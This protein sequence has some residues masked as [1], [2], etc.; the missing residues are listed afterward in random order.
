MDIHTKIPLKNFT[1]MKLGGIARF[2]VD[3]HTKDEVA[4]I[5]K[6]AKQNSLSVFVLGGGSNVIATDKGFNGII[7]RM[8]ISGFEI[9]DDNPGSTTI[10]IGGGENWDSVVKR[11]VDLNL[12]GIESMSAIPGTAGAAPVQNV[13]AYGQ[14]IADTLV[15]LEAYDQENDEFVTLQ[16]SDCG[17]SYRDSIFKNEEKNRYVI[18]SITIKLSKDMPKPPFYAALQKY[19]DDNN[20]N[21]Y[22]PDII[23][24]AIIKIR[25]NKL[26][27]PQ[28]MPNTGS[29]FKNAIV[30]SWQLNDLR[31]IDANIPIYEMGDNLYKIPTGWLIEQAG[32]KGMLLHGMRIYD[33]NA[34]VLI[35][36]SATSYDD[37]VN[38]REEIIEAILSKF[39]ITIQQEPIEI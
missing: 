10:K 5:C 36:E 16:N 19:L 15:S 3:A 13:G 6:K 33:K 17:F 8:R 37:L 1:T 39:G 7:V 28:I 31:K 29:F 4:E 38:A 25:E 30:E 20:I 24:E 34:L 2:M 12:S 32:L 23:R 27:D 14:E 35:N 11:T 22:T 26:P 21:I 18:V 9:I